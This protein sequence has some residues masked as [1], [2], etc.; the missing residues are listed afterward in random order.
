MKFSREKEEDFFFFF[1][2]SCAFDDRL[3]M[4]EEALRI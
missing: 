3:K 1:P 4:V 2:S